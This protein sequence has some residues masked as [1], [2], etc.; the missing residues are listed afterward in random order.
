MQGETS[1]AAPKP[2]SLSAQVGMATLAL[3]SYRLF[4]YSERDLSITTLIFCAA[5]AWCT[6][7]LVAAAVTSGHAQGY[8]GG[9]ESG[10]MG[11]LVAPLTSLAAV[12]RTLCQHVPMAETARQTCSQYTGYF[13]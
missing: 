8:D 11:I 3:L 2:P 10:S 12:L 9:F 6:G 5:C 4:F 7:Q 13:G 1:D